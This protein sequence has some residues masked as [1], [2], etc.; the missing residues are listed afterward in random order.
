MNESLRI[1]GLTDDIYAASVKFNPNG[2]DYTYKTGENELQVG[3]LV[4]VEADKNWGLSVAQVTQLHISV[5]FNLPYEFKWIVMRIDGALEELRNI[6]NLE[7]E[8]LAAKDA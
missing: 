2:S 7:R 5:D 3:D 6:K 1:L 4:L 8:A